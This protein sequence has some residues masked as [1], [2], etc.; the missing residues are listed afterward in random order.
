MNV[1]VTFCST[2]YE[3]TKDR[4]CKEAIETDFFDKAL[5]FNEKE[6]SPELLKS[7]T[8]KIKKGL[9]HYSWKPDAIW[10]AMQQCNEGDIIVY[11]DAGCSLSPS[12][13]WEKFKNILNEYSVLSFNIYQRN[14]QW[15]R[16]TVFEHFAGIIKTDWKNGYQV[17]ANCLLVKNDEIGRQFVSEWRDYMINR[18]DLCGDVPEK[19]LEYEDARFI[20]N[21]YDQT[22]LTAL[23][24][25]YSD[26]KTAKMLW[27]HFE[28]FDPFRKQ[29]MRASRLRKKGDVDYSK[30]T[31]K[32]LWRLFRFYILYPITNN[33]I[34]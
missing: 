30:L 5:S 25:K 24:Y 27:E 20:E 10:L 1:F 21:R 2:D 4:I 8:F 33:S 15:T 26:N 16:K 22:I 34:H 12:K 19:E 13:E 7:D 3:W 29:S 9:G 14:Y 31:R 11:C 28:G 32:L 6:L 18:L 17:G 23:S